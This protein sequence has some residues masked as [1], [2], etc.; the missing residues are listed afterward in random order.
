M[1]DQFYPVDPDDPDLEFDDGGADFE[2]DEE[3]FDCGMTFD[4]HGNFTGC[5][6]S[7]TE[8]CDFD[9]PYRQEFE[10]EDEP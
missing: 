2:D 5:Q 6:L 4:E 9:C 10:S 7:G 1:S 3:M 8:E